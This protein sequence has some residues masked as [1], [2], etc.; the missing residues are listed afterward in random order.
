MRSLRRES[1]WMNEITVQRILANF[2][3]TLFVA[4]ALCPA[5]TSARPEEAPGP[6]KRDGTIVVPG[7]EL[8][9]SSYASPQAQA[10][11][12]RGAISRT[13]IDNSTLQR[14]RE[15]M[16]DHL[17]RPMI[18]KARQAYPVV[19]AEE[20]I[21]GVRAF[22]VVPES[23]VS[24]DHRDKLLINLHG[25]GYR[26]GGG[27][28]GL[29]EAIPMAATARMTVLTIDYRLAPEHVFPAASEDVV[30]VYR[31]LLE[32]YRAENIGI[33]GCDAGGTLT[34]MTIAM[35]DRVKLPL[36][37]AIGIFCAA[38][39][40]ERGGDSQTLA[41]IAM[42]QVPGAPPNPLTTSGGALKMVD[43]ETGQPPRA[44][45][46]TAQASDPLAAPERFPELL[47]KFPPTLLIVGGRAP[48][49][50][51]VTLTKRR[52]TLAGVDADLNIWDGMWHTF[53]YD[54]ELPESREAYSV[55]AAFFARHLGQR[56]ARVYK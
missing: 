42:G 53:M 18:E 39:T 23:G 41:P 36:P 52:M 48:E 56:S 6:V 27:Q 43:E 46:S 28:G 44:Y 33:Y 22:R 3:T 1:L 51:A 7:F 45:L 15:T 24:R 14:Y 32:H 9:V 16:D 54:V 20:R 34:A 13:Q 55:A 11:F 40:F 38:A 50:S 17:F 35:L 26:I 10:A 4:V 31:E 25:G 21:A 29:V 12:V 2:V 47:A 19:V 49:L 37:G 30:A 8:P 5:S